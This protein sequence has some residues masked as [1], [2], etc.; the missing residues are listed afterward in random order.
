MRWLD[1]PYAPL[2]QRLKRTLN[3]VHLRAR[4]LGLNGWQPDRVSDGLAAY[5]YN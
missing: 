2:M 1:R 4:K 5:N 3:A